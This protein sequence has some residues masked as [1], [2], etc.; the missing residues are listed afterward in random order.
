MDAH[1]VNCTSTLYY[2]ARY[3]FLFFWQQS[4]A[5]LEPLSHVTVEAD[6]YTQ[7]Q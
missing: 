3:Y 5:L 4:Q 6:D 7:L 1:L 2:E